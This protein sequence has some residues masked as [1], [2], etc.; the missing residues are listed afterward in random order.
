MTK[1][2]AEKTCAIFYA[3]LLDWRAKDEIYIALTACTRETL[4]LFR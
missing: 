2:L 1:M 4:I 3:I